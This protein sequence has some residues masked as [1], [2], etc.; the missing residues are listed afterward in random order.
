M[1]FEQDNDLQAH[2]E[3]IQLQPVSVS[4]DAT[5]WHLY[6]SG[7]LS[8]DDCGS[9]LNHAV[10]LVGYGTD[11]ETGM[12]YWLIRNRCGRQHSP[13]NPTPAASCCYAGSLLTKCVAGWTCL[14]RA[15]GAPAGAWTAT[16]RSAG[17]TSAP[18]TPTLR[19]A[20]AARAA[21]RT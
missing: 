17:L 11:E 3:A 9:T 8:F 19:T 10:L 7:V 16:S 2:L 6:H 18:S 1:G 15:A 20:W 12:D 21:R 4:V 13:V 5:N 14:F